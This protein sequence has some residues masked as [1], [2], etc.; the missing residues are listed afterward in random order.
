M[1]PTLALSDLSAVAILTTDTATLTTQPQVTE[2]QSQTLYC[3]SGPLG[4][5]YHPADESRCSRVHYVPHSLRTVGLA[6]YILTLMF[7]DIRPLGHLF[8]YIPCGFFNTDYRR[9]S[10]IGP[11]EKF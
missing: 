2:H 3:S 10:E 8:N 5:K 11:F 9:I 7:T 1:V 6:L 4:C